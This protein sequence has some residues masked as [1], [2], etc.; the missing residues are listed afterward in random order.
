MAEWFRTG[1][2]NMTLMIRKG[3]EG[4]FCRLGKVVAFFRFFCYNY[5]LKLHCIIGDMVKQLGYVPFLANSS[6]VAPSPSL[7]SQPVVPVTSV[8]VMILLLVPV[9]FIILTSNV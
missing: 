6:P 8:L 4:P 5:Y 7:P 2:F 1:Y 3:S 9:F